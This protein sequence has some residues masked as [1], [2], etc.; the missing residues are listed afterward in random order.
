MSERMNPGREQ[1]IREDLRKGA[2]LGLAGHDIPELLAEIDATRA[3]RDEALAQLAALREAMEAAGVSRGLLHR[4]PTTLERFVACEAAEAALADTAAAA[5]AYTRRVR[6][7]ALRGALE[8]VA[9][10][11]HAATVAGG[12]VPRDLQGV[13]RWLR[14]EAERVEAGR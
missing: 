8:H 9:A 7:Q 4:S 13:Y 10:E 6:A 1:I 5:G 12:T 3:E 2:Y 11:M 14:A